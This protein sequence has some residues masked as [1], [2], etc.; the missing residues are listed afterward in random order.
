MCCHY[1]FSLYCKLSFLGDY[2]VFFSLSLAFRSL[3]LC[4]LCGF[5]WTDAFLE[6]T[7]LLE[8]VDLYSVPPHLESFSLSFF[9][10]NFFFRVVVSVQQNCE[11]S[12]RFP[13]YFLPPH[14]HNFLHYQH[15]DQGVTF[16]VTKDKPMLTHHNC[17]PNYLP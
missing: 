6:F 8:S 15:I 16:F 11:F 17:P 7:Y 12:T 3:I 1:D 2:F 13:I 10:N 9:E 14:M 4:G 5:L